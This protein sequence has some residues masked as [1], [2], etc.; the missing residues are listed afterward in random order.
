MSRVS[1]SLRPKVLCMLIS[2]NILLNSKGLQPHGNIKYRE[3]IL[4]LQRV[5]H[6]PNALLIYTVVRIFKNVKGV[7]AHLEDVN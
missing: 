2:F 4:L 6:S 7:N 3:M 1:G 5:A